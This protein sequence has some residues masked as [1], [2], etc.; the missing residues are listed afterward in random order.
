MIVQMQTGIFTDSTE[1]Q[2]VVE[3]A[4]AYGLRPEVRSVSG[5]HFYMTEVMLK[6][7][8]KVRTCVVPQHVFESMPGVNIA[9]RVTPPRLSLAYTGDGHAH[10]VQLGASTIVGNGLPCALVM[11]PCTVDRYIFDIARELAQLGVKRMRGGAWKPRSN[12][13]AFPGYGEQGL[14]WLLEAAGT[15]GM[16]TVFTEVMETSHL[17]VVQRVQ[18]EVGFTGTI[19]LWVGARTD[20]QILLRT[21]GIQRRYPVMIKHTLNARG[22][23]DLMNRGEWVLAG[24]CA[25]RDDGTLDEERSLEPGNDQLILCLRGVEKTDPR[26]PHRFDPNWFWADTLRHERVWTPVGMDP[27]HPAGTTEN[28]LVFRF[29]ADALRYRPHLIMVE[30]GY[31]AKGFSGDDFR[32]FC[33]VAQSVPLE[34]THEILGMV[35]EHNRIHY[36]K[37][38]QGCVDG[39]KR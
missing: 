13:Y 36:A 26:A 35:A 5:E 33:D 34:R 25:W 15:H 27:S 20:N 17:E 9:R 31:P 29:T 2:A 8:P 14:R 6:D 24:P 12:P 18:A 39:Q 22:V 30:G 4:K 37:A 1:V 32:G 23:Q 19:V 28:D 38:V 7:G 11:G 16:E 3:R 10:S 21:L